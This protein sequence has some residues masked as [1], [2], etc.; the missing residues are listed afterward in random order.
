MGARR[1]GGLAARAAAGRRSDRLP[2]R[3]WGRAP[4][5]GRRRAVARA[6]AGRLSPRPLRADQR[7]AA[8]ERPAVGQRGAGRRGLRV[9]HRAPRL[10][11]GDHHGRD[12][13]RAA[14]RGG[15]VGSPRVRGLMRVLVVPKWYPWPD[16]PVFGQFCR[17]QA[18]ALARRHDVVVL[19]SDAVR[20]PGFPVY[21]LSDAVEEGVRT[22]RVRYRRPA[23]RPLALGCQ[24]A[25]LFAALR[26]LRREGWVPDVVHAHVYSAA[27]AAIPLARVSRAPLV[28]TEHYT[29]FARGLIT[30][31]ER[32]LARRAFRA[33]AL[34]AAVSDDL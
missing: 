8:R 34:V 33:A 31:Y 15:A 22:L 3:G 27:L 17:E 11:A 18:R 14:R 21:E 24:L 9:P 1:R 32:L 5:G 20:H 16:R 2:R 7:R 4:A 10:P 19:A 23:L 25:G 12:G 28:V 13:G 29:G 6:R 26:R 30:G